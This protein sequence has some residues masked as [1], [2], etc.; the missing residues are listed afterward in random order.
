MAAKHRAP[1][2][3]EVYPAALASFVNAIDHA[4]KSGHFNTTEGFSE[5]LTVGLKSLG[6]S[7][8]D[9]A[10]DENISKGAIS[11]WQN[12]HALPSAPTRKTV[13]GWMRSAADTQLQK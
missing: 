11:K 4:E 1:D 9:L 2:L 7:A 13:I 5:L 12:G 3:R 8:A 10:R 6:F